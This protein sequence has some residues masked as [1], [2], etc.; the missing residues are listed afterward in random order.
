MANGGWHGTIEE[1]K[2]IEAPLL[3]VDP[4]IDEFIQNN[5]MA[6]TKNYKDWPE[7]SIAWTENNTR[8][9]IQLY[10]ADIDK[11]SWNIWLCCSQDRDE[12]RFW[13]QEFLIS[14]QRMSEF[15]G[16]LAELL[17]AAKTRLCD[18]STRPDKLEFATTVARL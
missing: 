5:G 14:K 1:W 11:I 17:E 6:V 16:R 13:R 12:S 7:R 15:E 8:L 4:Q 9:L 18:W 3:R 2:R 10:L